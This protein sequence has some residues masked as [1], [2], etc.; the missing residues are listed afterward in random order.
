L[1]GRLGHRFVGD[2]YD[3]DNGDDSEDDDNR[4]N[5]NYIDDDVDTLDDEEEEEE[6]EGRKEQKTMRI[7]STRSASAHQI[8]MNGAQW[9]CWINLFRMQQRWNEMSYYMWRNSCVNGL[10]QSI[11]IQACEQCY[12]LF[13]GESAFEYTPEIEIY[14]QKSSFHL[15]NGD[16]N[17]EQ[18][19]V[20]HN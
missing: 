4:I 20:T 12:S 2:T 18:C 16:P 17:V 10:W 14:F 3:D 13:G 11:D 19:I 15:S 5:G 7:C 1:H 9:F 6:E 8:V